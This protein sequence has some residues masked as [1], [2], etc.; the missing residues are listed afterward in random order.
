MATMAEIENS[1]TRYLRDTGTN[2]SGLAAA[3][4]KSPST[5]TRPLKGERNPSVG[6]ARAVE[7]VT[8]GK[9]TAAEFIE[10]CIHRQPSEQEVS[11]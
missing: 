2:L 8:N 5:L 11:A 6:L 7:R 3:M 10:A 1:L 4:G 9:V